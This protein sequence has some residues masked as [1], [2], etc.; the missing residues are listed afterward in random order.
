MPDFLSRRDTWCIFLYSRARQTQPHM[1]KE[2]ATMT[3]LW[4][5]AHRRYPDMFL[6]YLPLDGL[7]CYWYMHTNQKMTQA[8]KHWH[9]VMQLLNASHL[10]ICVWR[11]FPD[12]KQRVSS[13]E[14]QTNEGKQNRPY[15][16]MLVWLSSHNRKHLKPVEQMLGRGSER[17]PEARGH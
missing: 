12:G 4:A 2:T 11:V 5:F 10:P 8:I 13:T 9:F 6:L 14:S 3:I 7:H 17:L 16:E 1:H 15:S